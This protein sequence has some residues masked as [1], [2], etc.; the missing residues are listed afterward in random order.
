MN[1]K[2]KQNDT[3]IILLLLFRLWGNSPFIGKNH[4]ASQND[5]KYNVYL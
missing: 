2:K 3:I 4:K 1:I 5:W